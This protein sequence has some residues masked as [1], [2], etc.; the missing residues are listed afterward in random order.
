MKVSLREWIVTGRFGSIEL[1]AMRAD[2]ERHLGLPKQWSTPANTPQ[3]AA[4]WKYGD[5]E[6]YFQDD[7][8]WMIL[9]D[10]FEVPS[11]DTNLKLDAWIIERTC[12]PSA[13]E[14]HLNDKGI[15]YRVEDFPYA[16]NGIRI[17]VESGTTLTF[18]GEDAAQLELVSVSHSWL[19]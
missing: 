15:A 6:F 18:C 19:D 9:G 14:R 7:R 11:G 10:N 12:Q 2:V 5:I 1:G 8:L 16:D 17:I 13:M 4:I 3:T